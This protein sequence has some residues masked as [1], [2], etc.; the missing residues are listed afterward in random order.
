MVQK[1]NWQNWKYIWQQW[2]GSYVWNISEICDS[3]TLTSRGT[4]H[5]IRSMSFPLYLLWATF[6]T[7]SQVSL[8]ERCSL[9]HNFHSYLF[10][11]SKKILRGN[12]SISEPMPAKLLQ[13]L[14][15][16]RS[17]S[18]SWSGCGSGSKRQKMQKPARNVEK[19]LGRI[20][21][22]KLEWIERKLW[23]R[24]GESRERNRKWVIMTKLE[25]QSDRKG[26][27]DG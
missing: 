22:A 20:W 18:W 7:L 11:N 16:S 17:F 24:Q 6:A 5:K 15:Q 12:I 19:A 3:S 10:H 21:F 25:V 26:T 2:Y 9:L 23:K 8:Q 13:S 1:Y 14:L 27:P 4:F